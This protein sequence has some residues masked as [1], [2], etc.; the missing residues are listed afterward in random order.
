MDAS[1]TLSYFFE[2]KI[3]ATGNTDRHRTR[4]AMVIDNKNGANDDV[5]RRRLIIAINNV[6]D[7]NVKSNVDIDNAMEEL[8]PLSVRQSLV[9][10]RMFPILDK[11]IPFPKSNFVLSKCL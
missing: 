3:I 6:D 2:E 7:P 5:E 1:C 8:Y 10:L 4:S 9:L 11:F